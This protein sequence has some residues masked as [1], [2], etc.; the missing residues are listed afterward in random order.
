FFLSKND[1]LNEY[2]EVY[3][4]PSTHFPMIGRFCGS[5]IVPDITSTGSDLLLVFAS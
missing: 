1:C 2:V 5:D 3:D 4:G